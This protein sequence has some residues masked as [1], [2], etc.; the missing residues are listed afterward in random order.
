MQLFA[1]ITKFDS[2]QRLVWGYA[3]TETRDAQGE[4]V[5]REA[6]EAALPAYMRFGNI[7][8]MHQPSAVGVATA[9]ELDDRGLYVVAKVVDAAAWEKVVAG[10]YK[11]FS[12][13]GRVMTRDADDP[14]VIT[15]CSI[16]EISLADR[17]AN[18]ECVFDLWKADKA[19]V[20]TVAKVGARHSKAD[21][22]RVQQMHDTA[23]ELGACCPDDAGASAPDAEKHDRIDNL[24]K[25]TADADALSRRLDDLSRELASLQRRLTK[26]EATPLPPKGALRAIAKGED[27]SETDGVDRP[28]DALAAIR[29]A[30]TRPIPLY[31]LRK[32]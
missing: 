23:V 16:S 30:Q 20:T 26:I 10:V 27:V 32:V 25:R 17:P 14:S 19:P 5:K 8:E 29:K 15:G 4:I 9:A 21:L 12:I 7:R 3:S 28:D 13:G 6:I 1:D 11:G 31:E 2:A 22:E 18:P 24:A